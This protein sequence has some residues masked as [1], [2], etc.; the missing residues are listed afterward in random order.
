MK[1]G[2][3]TIAGGIAAAVVLFGAYKYWDITRYRAVTYACEEG[4]R[5]ISLP[6]SDGS[7]PYSGEYYMAGW[8]EWGELTITGFPALPE[9]PFH[10]AK[11]AT[12]SEARTGEWYDD[13]VL[14]F[15]PSR[16]AASAGP[17]SA[18]RVRIV[19][20]YGGSFFEMLAY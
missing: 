14:H 10:F 11:G 9:Q 5:T 20:R 16:E 18:C 17:N 19:Y 12:I 13:V 6:S 8:V 3:K 15:E 7:G 2:W 4:A 1:I